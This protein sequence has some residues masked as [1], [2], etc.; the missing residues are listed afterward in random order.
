MSGWLVIYKNAQKLSTRA[1]TK[2]LIDKSISKVESI[3][4][5][6]T[7]Y[8]IFKE[9]EKEMDHDL[10]LIQ[11]MG[12]ITQCAM[13]IVFLSNRKLIVS[14][15]FLAELAETCTLDSENIKKE[16]IEERKNRVHRIGESSMELIDHL[17]NSF[18]NSYKPT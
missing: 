13:S 7:E 17:N 10:Y 18:E 2:A 11:V 8:W 14:T 3:T 12:H 1:E 16:S 6:A 4:T 5:L 9:K 15:D